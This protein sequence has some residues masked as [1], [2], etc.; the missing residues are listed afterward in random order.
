MSFMTLDGHLSVAISRFQILKP[1]EMSSYVGRISYMAPFSYASAN[2]G[3]L[4]HPTGEKAPESNLHTE[5]LY[6]AANFSFLGGW[7]LTGWKG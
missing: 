1:S 3:R 4:S 7:F 5:W 6:Q 2:S